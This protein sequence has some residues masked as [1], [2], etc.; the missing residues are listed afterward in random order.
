MYWKKG[1]L[2]EKWSEKLLKYWFVKSFIDFFCV[3]FSIT[4]I[5]FS[6][7]VRY[8]LI[9]K[10][11]WEIDENLSGMQCCDLSDEVLAVFG[12]MRWWMV[13]WRCLEKF[14]YNKQPLKVNYDCFWG[15]WD[16]GRASK[17]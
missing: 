13:R 6:I 17:I 4:M 9:I 8:D 16:V 5:D 12:S 14:E 15:T 1:W 11:M 10:G 7:T 3:R 2:I